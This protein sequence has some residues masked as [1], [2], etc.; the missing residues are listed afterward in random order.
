MTKPKDRTEGSDTVGEFLDRLTP[1]DH[2]ALTTVL[3]C[4]VPD[5]RTMTDL[6]SWVDQPAQPRTLEAV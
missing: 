3:A 1:D 4:M 5:D 6:L 2:Y